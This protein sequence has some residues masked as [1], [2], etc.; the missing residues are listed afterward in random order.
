MAL[1]TAHM[2]AFLCSL[3]LFFFHHT[4][5][6]SGFNLLLKNKEC[7]VSV[8]HTDPHCFSLVHS[9]VSILLWT[10][11]PHWCVMAH[12]PPLGVTGA[13][14]S[15]DDAGRAWYHSVL[16]DHIVH[17]V[18][19]WLKPGLCHQHGS[20]PLCVCVCVIHTLSSSFC[21]GSISEFKITV[22]L[23]YCRI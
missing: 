22:A 12:R 1:I 8:F 19:T 6:W 11:A 7:F 5:H 16:L 10:K 4:S 17:S 2:L 13:A 9:L 3:T 21:S 14:N 23:N 15:L 18:H 20:C